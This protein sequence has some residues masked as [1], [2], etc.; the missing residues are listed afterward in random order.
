MRE[1][2]AKGDAKSAGGGEKGIFLA[3]RVACLNRR[4][5][6]RACSQATYF[7]AVYTWR[8]VGSGEGERVFFSLSSPLAPSPI[9]FFFVPGS[10]FARLNFLLNELQ[11]KKKHPK[12]PPATQAILCH[13]KFAVLSMGRRFTESSR[14]CESCELFLCFA[15]FVSLV[16][17]C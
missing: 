4:A 10:I 1:R 13:V 3:P 17:L 2:H 11:K 7:I 15:P 5:D 16:L 6:R 9:I 8:G 12:K 14:C